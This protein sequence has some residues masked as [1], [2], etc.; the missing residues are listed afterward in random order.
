MLLTALARIIAALNANR[1]EGEIA[2]AVVLGI[3]LALVPVGN[4]VWIVLFLFTF[5]VKVN[6]GI[7]LLVFGL[8]TPPA[9]LLDSS[10]DALGYRVLTADGLQEFLTGAYNAP[11]GPFLGIHNTSVIGGLLVSA[12]I[13]VPVY[14][15]FRILVRYYRDTLRA[16]IVQS[17]IVRWWQR[18]PLASFIRRA[19][20]Q[21]KSM[22]EMAGFN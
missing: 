17:R 1:R 6:L 16:K 18:L 22:Y 20:N 14:Y 2:W 9:L 4:I 7:A 13:A 10:L 8:G 3:A 11:L 21:A 12:V 5:L 19:A 15:L